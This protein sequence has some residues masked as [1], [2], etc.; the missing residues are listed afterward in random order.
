VLA[1]LSEGSIVVSAHQIP[2]CPARADHAKKPLLWTEVF[3]WDE[4]AKWASI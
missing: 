2:S 3:A 1:G 4:T